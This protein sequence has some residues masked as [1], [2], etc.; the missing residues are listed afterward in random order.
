[1]SHLAAPAATNQMLKGGGRGEGRPGSLPA[2]GGP[3]LLVVGLPLTRK[4]SS[5]AL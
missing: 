4:L 3:A 5:R 2:W 1:M